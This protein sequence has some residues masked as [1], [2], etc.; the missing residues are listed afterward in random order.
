L[1]RIREATLLIRDRRDLIWTLLSVF[2]V[3][4]I[5]NKVDDLFGR[6]VSWLV[7]LYAVAAVV[8]LVI[9]GLYL[10]QRRQ[11]RV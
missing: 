6:E 9:L 4:L 7:W 1:R 3:A 5:L 2:A 10:R 8:D 11:R